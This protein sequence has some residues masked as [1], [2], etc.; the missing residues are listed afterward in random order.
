MRR[1]CQASTQSLAPFHKLMTLRAIVAFAFA[2]LVAIRAIQAE[3][4]ASQKEAF[5][6]ILKEAINKNDVRQLSSLIYTEAM[7]QDLIQAH[8][9]SLK[10]LV[11]MLNA[12]QHHL[13][14]KWEEPP[15][16]GKEAFEETFKG[17]HYF[18]NCE[19]AVVLRFLFFGSETKHR[20]I[21]CVGSQKL[22]I[23]GT[24][25]TPVP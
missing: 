8:E 18:P 14:Y 11:E 5:L 13:D 6:D 7:T 4:T 17:F 1:L 21:L 9:K 22:M 25:R 10:H 3:P 23:V 12:N 19:A 16:G 2:S 24:L 20:L 15:P